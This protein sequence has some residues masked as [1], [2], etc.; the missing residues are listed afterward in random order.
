MVNRLVK[1]V[2]VRVGQEPQVESI[3]SSLE[4]FQE[5]VGGSIGGSCL[6]NRVSIIANDDGLHLQLPYNRAGMVGDFFFCKHHHQGKEIDMKPNDIAW[7]LG[8]LK[9]N[10]HRPPRC[11]ICGGH[12]GATLFCPCRNVLIYCVACYSQLLD[13]LRER[14]WTTCDECCTLKGK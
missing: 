4:G 6:V 10:D 7:V 11:H 5:F 1:V 12:G 8:W 3:D 13:H 9:R 14:R 2:A